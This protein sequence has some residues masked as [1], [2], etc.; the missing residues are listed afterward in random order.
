MTDILNKE[1][2]GKIYDIIFFNKFI[3]DIINSI[4]IETNEDL[5][6]KNHGFILNMISS[7]YCDVYVFDHTEDDEHY[8]Y[9]FDDKELN[10]LINHLVQIKGKLFCLIDDIK[11]NQH[12]NDIVFKLSIKYR[13]LS[14]AKKNYEK[15][16]YEATFNIFDDV[17][18]D[19]DD[20]VDDD[21]D[22]DVDIVN[23]FVDDKYVSDDFVNNLFDDVVS[24]KYQ[25]YENYK[26]HK[27]TNISYIEQK[28]IDQFI[29][30]FI[31][32]KLDF[33]KYCYLKKNDGK[34]VD[35]FIK[36]SVFY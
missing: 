31:N 27:T 33:E 28:H 29:C 4:K 17:D 18:V 9:Y 12:D 16:K 1:H 35:H 22:V 2:D 15:M 5:I 19:D 13:D 36:Q 30:D 21:V 23:N 8:D 7:I 25:K 20:D 26:K 10:K 14:D 24:D 6:K 34:H 3:N 32:D 11:Q